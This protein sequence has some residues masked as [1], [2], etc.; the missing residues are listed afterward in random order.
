LNS[1][2]TPN[3][4]LTN[5]QNAAFLSNMS[6]VNPQIG[7]QINNTNVSDV[8]AA[9]NT[10][11]A[12]TIINTALNSGMDW[13][14]TYKKLSLQMANTNASG[15]DLQDLQ[16]AATIAKINAIRLMTNASV[17][18]ISMNVPNNMTKIAIP[19]DPGMATLLAQYT[20]ISTKFMN[21]LLK[22]TLPPTLAEL[23]QNLSLLPG[24]EAQETLSM[25]SS[26]IGNQYN[27][28][29]AYQKLRRA[30]ST[31][32]LYNVK[33]YSTTTRMLIN[34]IYMLSIAAATTPSITYS[35][36]KNI[37][38][39]EQTELSKI[40]DAY[41]VQFVQNLQYVRRLCLNL[42]MYKINDMSSTFITVLTTN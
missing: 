42:L 35:K 28:F 29:I 40:T 26:L 18:N 10:Q 12:T 7:V 23:Q 32:L 19:Q 14:Q 20:S 25:Q 5:L 24:L 41:E 6:G 8:I 1:G 34:D 21:V 37:S 2:N 4:V 27:F 13:N 39:Y 9:L 3:V 15:S 36:F 16:V 31:A 22:K 33:T 30:M 17:A 38:T 11:G